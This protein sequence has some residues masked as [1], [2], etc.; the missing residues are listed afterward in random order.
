MLL[1]VCLLQSV[2]PAIA[3]VVAGGIA[4]ALIGRANVVL[5]TEGISVDEGEDPERGGTPSADEAK[6]AAD[7]R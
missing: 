3:T 4:A 2:C 7:G 1:C 6:G 5:S